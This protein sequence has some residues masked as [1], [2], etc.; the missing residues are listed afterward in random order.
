MT[1]QIANSTLQQDGLKDS[2]LEF[3][4]NQLLIDL[5]GEYDRNLAVIEEA[6]DVQIVRRGNQL[7]I[8]GTS[9][10]LSEA[11]AVLQSLYQRLEIGRPI[12]A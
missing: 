1:T 3:P 4:D 10:G 11:T 12:E 9:A 6:L 2:L 5:C 7:S 8:L